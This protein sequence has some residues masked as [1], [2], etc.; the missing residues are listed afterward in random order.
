M[1]KALVYKK[2][3]DEGSA[4]FPRRLDCEAFSSLEAGKVV[5]LT[6]ILRKGKTVQLSVPH[7]ARPEST[8]ARE[9]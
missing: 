5:E 3:S 7:G 4:A 8:K 1:G 6:I 9:G 2:F